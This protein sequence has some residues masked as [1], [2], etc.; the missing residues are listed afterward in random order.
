MAT[1][2]T[3]NPNGRPPL[4]KSPAE[5]RDKIEAYFAKCDEGTPKVALD[6]KGQPVL[7]GDCN[8]IMVK[9]PTPYTMEGLAHF[10]GTWPQQL[11]AYAKKPEFSDIITYARNAI[12]AS[13]AAS[14]LTGAFNPKVVA[15][16]LAAWDAQYRITQQQEITVETVE[17]KLRRIANVTKQIEHAEVIPDAVVVG[18]G[19]DI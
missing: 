7:D 16:M 13:W 5:L 15:L 18:D 12:R 9:T 6:R 10:L 2:R 11:A 19:D 8:P 17:D 4:F 3:G 14:G 1:P